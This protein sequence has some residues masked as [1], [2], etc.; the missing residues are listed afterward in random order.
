MSLGC[1]KAI[2]PHHDS[3]KIQQIHDSRKKKKERESSLIPKDIEYVS[4]NFINNNIKRWTNFKTNS[5][6][7]YDSK[8]IYF[9]FSHPSYQIGKKK[10]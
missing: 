1:A 7:N 2:P 4:Q 8:H 10:V 5:L 6:Q 3:P 9:K